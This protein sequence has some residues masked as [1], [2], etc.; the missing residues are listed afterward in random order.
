M[1]LRSLYPIIIVL[2][3]AFICL[4]QQPS[5]PPGP[6]GVIRLRVRV[7]ISDSTRGLSRKRFF[8]IKGSAEQ[9]K[10]LLETIERHPVLSRNCYYRRIGASEALIKWLK[11]S[12]CESVYCRE[13]VAEDVAGP[14]V[15]PEFQAALVAGEKEFGNRDLARRWLTVN[16]PDNIRDGFYRARQ[17]E[18]RTLIKQAETTSGA[19]VLSVMGDRNGT[20]YFTDLE[21]GA[22]VIS[23]ILPLEVGNTAVLWNCGVVVKAGDLATEK[24]FL[25][26]N[27]PDKNVKCVGVEKPLP[28]CEA[29]ASSSQ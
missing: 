11:E 19:T 10:N 25:V 13:I 8:L 6:R 17:E 9:N 16:L 28:V 23:S 24:P 12:D 7:K 29:T 27:K 26:S 1:M 4:A 5:N 15:V 3:L 14:D 20:A 18:L 2:L 22:Y 21:P